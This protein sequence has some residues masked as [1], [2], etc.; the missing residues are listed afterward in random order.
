MSRIPVHTIDDAR[1]ASRPALQQ[2]QARMGRLLNIH[3]EMAHSPV[4]LATYA[5]MQAAVAE[6]STFDPW[7]REAIALAVA[8]VDGCDYCQSAHTLSGRR[9]GLSP[10]LMMAI[11][12]GSTTF[13]PKLVAL[14]A[15]AR[16]I[17]AN[18]GE[19]SDQTWKQ[20]QQAGW[21]D[22]ELTELFAHVAVNL[23]TN[24]FNHYARTDLDIPAVPG[25]T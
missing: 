5:G 23:F 6:H 13:D 8:A 9:A 21:T 3:A 20:A 22:V 18:V 17:A 15:V 10:E 12:A 25:L 19:V 11:R 16:E 2:M 7:V 1:P 14:L 4:V 24:Y